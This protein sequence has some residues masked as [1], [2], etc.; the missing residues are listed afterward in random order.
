[1]FGSYNWSSTRVLD[2]EG[3]GMT[4]QLIRYDI[5]SNLNLK[6]EELWVWSLGRDD[7]YINTT[8][9]QKWISLRI[10]KTAN[11]KQKPMKN[12]WKKHEKPSVLLTWMIMI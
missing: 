3:Y 7:I 10:K 8:R 2:R 4:R 1:M 9:R 12:P 6:V 5:Y 11:E